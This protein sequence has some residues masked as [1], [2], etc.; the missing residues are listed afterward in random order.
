[1]KYYLPTMMAETNTV[2]ETKTVSETMTVTMN[3]GVVSLLVNGS[4][5]DL[6][7][8]EN[9]GLED[10]LEYGLELG[11]GDVLRHKLCLELGLVFDS[12]LGY[13]VILGDNLL[14][15]FG[16]G[17]VVGGMDGT[18]KGLVL[19]L[20]LDIDFGLNVSFSDILRG[21]CRY[22]LSFD[23]SLNF[24]LVESGGHNLGSDIDLGNGNLYKLCLDKSLD[25]SLGVALLHSLDRG[26]VGRDRGWG[27]DAIGLIGGDEVPGCSRDHECYDE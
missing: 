26:A 7:L 10:G 9:L 6:S 19:S 22:N 15:D 14:L 24:S 23:L 12:S 2:S 8:V 11:L 18:D 1:L 13:E 27:N 5:D 4:L 20:V 21:V 16:N 25:N 17:V 3:D